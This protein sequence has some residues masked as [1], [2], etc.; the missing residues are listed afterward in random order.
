MIAPS[1]RFEGLPSFEE[2]IGNRRII[3]AGRR[4]V[5]TRCE[6]KH[7]VQK[8]FPQGCPCCLGRATVLKLDR[9]ATVTALPTKKVNS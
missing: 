3:A 4:V 2:R 6:G 9:F 1:P 8:P 5:C 7:I